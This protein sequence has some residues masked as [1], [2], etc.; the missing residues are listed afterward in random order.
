MTAPVSENTIDSRPVRSRCGCSENQTV[1]CA[2][3]LCLSVD[4]LKK[5][6]QGRNDVSVQRSFCQLLKLRILTLLLDWK[7]CSKAHHSSVVPIC[8]VRTIQDS[9]SKFPCERLCS[10][11]IQMFREEICSVVLRVRSTHRQTFLSY[12]LLHCQASYFD[13]FESESESIS[14]RD[15]TLQ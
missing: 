15:E 11:S 13:V 5:K 1:Y 12:P 3:E 2:T 7:R 6:Q 14:R 8:T 10:R 9:K 4:K